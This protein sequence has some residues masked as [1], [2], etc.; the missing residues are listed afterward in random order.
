[1]IL[2]GLFIKSSIITDGLSYR[3]VMCYCE[4]TVNLK[5]GKLYS[6]YSSGENEGRL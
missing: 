4:C 5:S 6:V 3:K 2:N 1:M